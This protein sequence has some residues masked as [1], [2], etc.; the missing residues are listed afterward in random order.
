MGITSR[1]F[2][3][4]IRPNQLVKEIIEH[5]SLKNREGVDFNQA[6]KKRY[7]ILIHSEC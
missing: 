7:S 5:K 1:N 4:N 3:E 6:V 2:K